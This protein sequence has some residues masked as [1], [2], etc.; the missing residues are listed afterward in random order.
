MPYIL[1]K[2]QIPAPIPA[3][4]FLVR[5]GLSMQEAQRCINKGRVVYQGK[6]L[7]NNEKARILEK[8]VEILVFNPKTFGL[9]PLFENEHFALFN[10]PHKMLIHPKGYF[11]HHTL[12][13]EICALYGSEAHLVHRIDKETSGLVLVG[14]HKK[15]TAD[16]GALFLNNQV[17]KEYLALVRGKIP[18]ADFCVDLP[19]ATQPKRRDLSVRS[20]CMTSN[21]P[22]DL[23]KRFKEARTEFE[24]L[25]TLENVKQESLTLLKVI[26]KTGRTHQ[27]RLH[28]SA[29]GFPILGDPLYG[30]TDEQSREY[31][32]CE[33]I[34]K[35]HQGLEE[36]KYLE[37]FG[38][39]RLMLHAYGL[40]FD[41]QG[42]RYCFKSLENFNLTE[43]LFCE[44]EKS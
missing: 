33:F 25:G 12:L 30:A 14:K 15:S 36:Q 37:Y 16:L 8:D 4:L 10:K 6:K 35:G 3:Y 9:K 24:I 26:P 44:C 18:F 41:Y 23:Q 28:L 39:R 5:L 1:Q 32:D 22:K 13:D 21:A 29:L 7:T 20:V 11:H 17:K 43:H 38:A 40:E 19:I 42:E 34:A 31:L 27:I 2:F